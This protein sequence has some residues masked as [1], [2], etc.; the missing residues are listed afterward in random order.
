MTSP[1]TQAEI[2]SLIEFAKELERRSKALRLGPTELSRRTEMNGTK[3]ISAGYISDILRI[4][5]G[6]SKKRFKVGRD[7]IIRIARAVEWNEDEA[8]D[9]AGFK[10]GGIAYADTIEEALD[11]AMFFDRK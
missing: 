5:R 3:A 10:S 7:K 9:C 1:M 4:G 2:A 11:N 8:L 6:H